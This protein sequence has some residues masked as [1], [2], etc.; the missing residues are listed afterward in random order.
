M[1]KGF[2]EDSVTVSSR[3]RQCPIGSD[4]YSKSAFNRLPI[5]PRSGN[6]G[7]EMGLTS[8]IYYP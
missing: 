3:M 6:D 4:I 2:F 8:L 7:V 5:S 1:V